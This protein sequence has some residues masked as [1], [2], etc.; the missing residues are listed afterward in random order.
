MSNNWGMK[1]GTKKIVCHWVEGSNVCSIGKK[2]HPL[3]VRAKTYKKT[4]KEREDAGGGWYGS[5]METRIAEVTDWLAYFGEQLIG[6][7]STYT[8]MFL[9]NSDKHHLIIK[10]TT[11]LPLIQTA[12]HER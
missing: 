2:Y 12:R 10:E 9:P 3:E 1:K 11:N 7:I 5:N 6:E 4:I 8:A